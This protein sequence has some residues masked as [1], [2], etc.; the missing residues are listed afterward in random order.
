MFVVSKGS[1][2]GEVGRRE[3][4]VARQGEEERWERDSA[5]PE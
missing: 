1:R 2:R 4:E 3:R 5:S